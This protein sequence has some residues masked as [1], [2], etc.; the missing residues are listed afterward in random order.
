[1][2]EKLILSIVFVLIITQPVFGQS[3]QPI[4]AIK[5]RIDQVLAILK[6][7]HYQSE[8]MKAL[9]REKIR[10]LIKQVF[11]FNEMARRATA[12]YWKRFSQVEKGEFSRLFSEL[13]ENTYLG[14]IQKYRDEKIVYLSQENLSNT[15]TL[16]KTKLTRENLD[17][18][19]FYSMYKSDRGWKVYDV[20]IE[21]VSLV[22]NYRAQFSQILMNR[23]PAKLIEMLRKKVAE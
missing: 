20:T 22:K 18:P 21:G 7:P 15:K 5:S 2:K 10:G 12:Q 13:L 14:R 17:I 16:V 19:I 8:S 23:S 4:D 3:S 9:S 11:D 1:M 6:D